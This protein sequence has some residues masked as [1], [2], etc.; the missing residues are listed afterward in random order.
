MPRLN[1]CETGPHAVAAH[2]DTSN[3][4]MARD[5]GRGAC[6][7]PL[8]DA[9][10]DSISVAASLNTSEFFVRAFKLSKVGRINL[11]HCVRTFGISDE[12]K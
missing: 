5:E 11:N 2:L 12:D 9:A 7:D 4:G 6:V 3:N 1:N 10:K 8:L